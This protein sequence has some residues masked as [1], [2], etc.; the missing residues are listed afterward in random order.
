MMILLVGVACAIV[1]GLSIYAG[2]LLWLLKKQKEQQAARKVAHEKALASHDRKVL[3]SVLIIVKAMQ[4]EQCDYSEGCWRLSVLLDSLKLSNQLDNEFPAIF[5]LYNQI[6]HLSILDE[7]KQ[8]A[9]RDR[10]KQDVERM[11]IE[12]ACVDD[13]G[14]TLPL[15]HQYTTERLA[16][17]A[18][19]V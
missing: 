3:Q 11:K 12:A 1:L 17:L 19:D 8:M 13:I 5:N 7:R 15:L 2:R 10:M 6:K 14:K 16:Y 9:K 4:E 18:N